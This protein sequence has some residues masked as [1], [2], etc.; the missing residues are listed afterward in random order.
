MTG[1]T[2]VTI[3][4]G[5]FVTNSTVTFG[6][7]A[8]TVDSVSSDGTT[9]TATSPAGTGTV[10][11]TVTAFVGTD[12]L[13]PVTLSNAFTYV[14]PLSFIPKPGASLGY[15][16]VGQ[17]YTSSD[18]STYVSVTGGTPP[19]TYSVDTS[20]LPPG[21]GFSGGVISG[22]PTVAGT[23]SVTVDVTDNGSPQETVDAPDFFGQ[24]Q[25][26]STTLSLIVFGISPTSGP[27]AGGTKVTI[28]GGGF[29]TN[30]TVTFGTTPATNVNVVSGTNNTELTCDSPA[31]TGTVGVTVTAFVGTDALS[32]VTLS[33]AFTYTTT[34]TTTN[35]ATGG[36]QILLTVLTDNATNLKSGSATLNGSI[37]ANYGAAVDDYGFYWGTGTVPA[38]KVQVGTNNY[39][40]PFT[41]NL[42]NLTPGTTYCFEAYAHNQEGLTTGAVQ[43]FTTVVPAPPPVM[44]PV[45]TDV[46]ST[47]WAYAAIE[48]LAGLGYASGY[49]DGTFRP[50]D[51]ITR[52]EF[53]AIMDK[54]LNITSYSPQTPTFTDVQQGDWFYNAVEEAVYAGIAKGYG[55]G[56]FRPNNPI[57]RQEIAC[58]LIQA[59]G[60]A[61]WLTPML[62]LRPCSPT[63]TTSPG[64]QEGS[65]T[66]PCSRKL[67]AAT[68]TTLSSLIVTPPGRR[69][70]P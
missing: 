5:G 8:A 65:S 19:Y 63:I 1:G 25:T 23:Y 18:I 29:V 21:L 9:I 56:T 52:A 2:L 12:A 43:T 68:Q 33:N 35:L 22:T 45:F 34:T 16:I 6:T 27:A 62:R 49:P 31:G 47:F 17:L 60:K 50:N 24:Q 44:G 39:T 30:S 54:V 48:N 32:P 3:T 40:G 51:Q 67:S 70:A 42:S 15:G 38:T 61:S 58:V 66:K 7:T 13:S 11:V 57:S 14:A 10:D 26:I 53:C 28:T 37:T 59:L 20:T 69:P 36:T 55:D 46:P 41:C 4:G 64:G